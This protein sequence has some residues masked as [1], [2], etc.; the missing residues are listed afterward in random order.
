MLSSTIN[1]HLTAFFLEI[2][3]NWGDVGGGRLSPGSIFLIAVGLGSRK[4]HRAISHCDR[5]E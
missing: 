3:A 1:T 5:P 4:C 2:N